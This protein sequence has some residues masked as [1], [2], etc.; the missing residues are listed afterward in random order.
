MS[1]DT[2]LKLDA[3]HKEF[4]ILD[5]KISRIEE[6]I[7]HMLVFI[8]E[9]FVAM[10]EE[11]DTEEETDEEEMLGGGEGWIAGLDDWKDEYDNN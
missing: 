4:L 11:Y 10:D 3:L 9:M 1:N 7:N 8:E 5:A 6:K 2:D